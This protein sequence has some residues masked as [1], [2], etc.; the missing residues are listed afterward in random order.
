[1]RK[2]MEKAYHGDANS[3]VLAEMYKQALLDLE[4]QNS[5]NGR[6]LSLLRKLEASQFQRSDSLQPPRRQETTCAYSCLS[7]DD[8]VSPS[9]KGLMRAVTAPHLDS[10]VPRSHR[11]VSLYLQ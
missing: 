8:A 1:M 10:S 9:A 4:N 11:S 3:K 5:K 6:K 7:S 2:N